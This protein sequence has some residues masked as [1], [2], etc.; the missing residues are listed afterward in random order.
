[1]H[2]SVWLWFR[3][4]KLENKRNKKSSTQ[5]VYNFVLF[6]GSIPSRSA[7]MSKSIELANRSGRGLYV[8]GAH[9]VQPGAHFAV[10]MVFQG[11]LF[12]AGNHTG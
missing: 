3:W 10:D 6:Q 9:G 11:E 8:Y 2:C 1:V 12:A 5:A 4:R 7:T